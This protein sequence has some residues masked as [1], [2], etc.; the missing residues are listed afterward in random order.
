MLCQISHGH[1]NERWPKK[2]FPRS[3]C[4][5]WGVGVGRNSLDGMRLNDLGKNFFFRAFNMSGFQSLNIRGIQ[6][7]LGLKEAL[8]QTAI[9]VGRS[10]GRIP[11][12]A[13]R[14]GKSRLCH[15]C[16]VRSISPLML[17]FQVPRCWTGLGKHFGNC[18]QL[19]LVVFDLNP[20]SFGRRITRGMKEQ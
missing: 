10:F 17:N 6:L 18:S 3:P 9:R 14:V 5:L 13:H 7:W 4:K 8:G 1:G 16:A 12:S 20:E 2:V 11:T 19:L 15:V